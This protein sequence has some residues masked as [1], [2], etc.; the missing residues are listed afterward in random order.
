[1][2]THTYTEIFLPQNQWLSNLYMNQ[3]HV[4][5]L[6]KQE[7]LGLSPW[8]SLP[9]GLGCVHACVCVCTCV[10]LCKHVLNLIWFYDSMDWSLSGSSANRIFQAKN[11]AVGCHFLLQGIFPIQGSKD[12]SPLSP[13]LA[14][15]FFT[16]VPPGKPI[17]LGGA[18][19][20]TSNCLQWMLLLLVPGPHGKNYCPREWDKMDVSSESIW[21]WTQIFYL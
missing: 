15:E 3:H 17:D 7:F 12:K 4:Q 2:Q 9:V 14:G 6:L 16:A 18:T 1:M 20:F 11:T 21:H 5:G 13:A 19:E 8:V 10:C